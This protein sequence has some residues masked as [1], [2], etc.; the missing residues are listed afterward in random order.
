MM[1]YFIEK[2][3][4]V[5]GSIL[6][7]VIVMALLMGIGYYVS[8]ICPVFSAGESTIIFCLTAILFI[9]GYLAIPKIN[10]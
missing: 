6:T 4:F 1:K 3:A 7:V 2:I 10:K 9:V 8:K 5:A